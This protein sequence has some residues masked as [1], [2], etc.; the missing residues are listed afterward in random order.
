M[1]YGKKKKAIYENVYLITTVSSN[2]SE[3]DY[4]LG[5]T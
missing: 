3:K 4:I 1:H 2:N 5:N